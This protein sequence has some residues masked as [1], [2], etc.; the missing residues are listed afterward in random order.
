[1][2]VIH[3]IIR[4]PT[5]FGRIFACYSSAKGFIYAL[6][7]KFKQLKLE[8][9]PDENSLQIWVLCKEEV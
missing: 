3:K 6:S 1:M 8:K 7:K 4:Q 5:E 9:R 2:E